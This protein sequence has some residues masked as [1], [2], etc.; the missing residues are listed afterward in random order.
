MM[1]LRIA[2]L[3]RKRESGNLFGIPWKTE[4]GEEFAA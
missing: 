2:G 3:I 1:R 4:Q